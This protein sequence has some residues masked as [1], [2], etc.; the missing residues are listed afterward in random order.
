[1]DNNAENDSPEDSGETRGHSDAP[2]YDAELAA[3]LAVAAREMTPVTIPDLPRLRQ[4][5]QELALQAR[6]DVLDEG[7]VIEDVEVA[8][9][10][11]DH[12]EMSI[13]RRPDSPNGGPLLY[14]IHGGGM[15][16]GT[17][18]S[19]H[20]EFIKWIER[21]GLVVATIEYRLAPEHRFPTPHE[22]CY[23]G[24]RWLDRNAPSLGVQV[25][26]SLVVGTSAGGGLAAA[27]AL[28]ARDRSGPKAGGMMLL[29][30]M[31]DDRPSWPSWRQFPT[32]VWNA[33]ENRLAWDA[34]LGDETGREDMSHHAV[35]GRTRDFR[36]LP[37]TYV[38]VGSAELFRDESV[39]FASGI[40]AAGGRA[41]LHVWD[42]GFHGFDSHTHTALAQGATQARFNWMDRV[43]G[44]PARPPG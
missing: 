21:Y 5:D 30:P 31:L 44:L 19:G 1:M 26:T 40:W 17:R 23:S 25:D 43:L 11:G 38:E 36:E 9:A 29:A 2:P 4:R 8:S 27:V 13:I 7:L 20:E 42:G 32:G 39:A 3:V 10:D 28:M 12:V 14:F 35:P 6:R 16:L 18:W 41:E 34:L 37:T 33:S 22:D 24:L 15:M